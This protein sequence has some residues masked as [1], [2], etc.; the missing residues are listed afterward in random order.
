MDRHKISHLLIVYGYDQKN[1]RSINF[2]PA[3]YKIIDFIALS[4]LK[5][6]VVFH[7]DPKMN[8]CAGQNL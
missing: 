1:M 4:W 5:Y 2:F 7:D 6:Y 8:I 3:S